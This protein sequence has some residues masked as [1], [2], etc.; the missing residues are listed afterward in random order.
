[1]M[2]TTVRRAMTASAGTVA[3]GGTNGRARGASTATTTVAFHGTLSIHYGGD[4]TVHE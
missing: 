4:A 1:M 2:I 3:H